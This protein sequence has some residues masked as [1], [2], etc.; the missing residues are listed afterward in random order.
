M[1]DYTSKIL[2]RKRF[3]MNTSFCNLYYKLIGKI[4]TVIDN[5]YNL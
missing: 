1:I 4:L 5:I 3:K 2:Q